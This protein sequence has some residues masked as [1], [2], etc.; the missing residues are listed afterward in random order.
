MKIGSYTDDENKATIV[1]EKLIS[2]KIGNSDWKVVL[3]GEN[4]YETG[5]YFVKK[6]TEL[7][8]FGKL[9]KN[10]LINYNT[11]ETI[12]LEEGNYSIISA[13][14]SLAV[15]DHIIFNLDSSVID[16]NVKNTKED[17]KKVKFLMK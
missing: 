12:I 2:K 3:S 13:E 16:G 8:G 15:K 6:G 10:W 7:P 17:L 5:W 1:G 9:E 4:V 11:G 14:D